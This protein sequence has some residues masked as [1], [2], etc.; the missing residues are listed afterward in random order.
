MQA[1]ALSKASAV[2]ALPMQVE[3]R[4][5]PRFLARGNVAAA[6]R[7]RLAPRVIAMLRACDSIVLATADADGHPYVQHRGGPP[8]WLHVLDDRT[9]AFADFAG[10]RQYTTVDNLAENARAF[11]LLVDYERGHRIKIAGRARVSDDPALIASLTPAGYPADVER[12]IV[13]D[14]D[15]WS[16]NCAQHIPRRVKAPPTP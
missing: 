9:L 1:S 2:P 3:S 7:A 6:W 16:A 8:G 15:A 5:L 11:L 4:R 10:N 12:A 14:V 13:F